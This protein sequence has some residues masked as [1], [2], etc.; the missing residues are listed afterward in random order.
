MCTPYIA[1]PRSSFS[2]LIIVNAD[3]SRASLNIS[4]PVELVLA[5]TD[6]THVEQ[7]SETRMLGSYW[8]LNGRIFC[9]KLRYCRAAMKASRKAGPK[10]ILI[11]SCTDQGSS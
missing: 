6:D 4:I 5:Y 10:S 2:L 8:I 3:T 11:G 1:I 9:G 7:P